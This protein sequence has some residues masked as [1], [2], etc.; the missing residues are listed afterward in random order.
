MVAIGFGMSMAFLSC[1]LLFLYIKQKDNTSIVIKFSRSTVDWIQVMLVL[2][3]ALLFS[4]VI[5]WLGSR[6]IV[7]LLKNINVGILFSIRKFIENGILIPFICILVSKV[8]FKAIKK[9]N[10]DYT[11]NYTENLAKSCMMVLTIILSVALYI[12]CLSMMEYDKETDFFLNRVL[13]W[14]ITAIG[15]KYGFGF[16]C[17]KRIKEGNGFF[18]RL[19][20]ALKKMIEDIKKNY[21]IYISFAICLV[22]IILVDKSE[23]FFVEAILSFS[24]MFVVLGLLLSEYIDR[25]IRP[26]EKNG[27]KRFDKVI[28]KY[29]NSKLIVGRLGRMKYGIKN[30]QIIIEKLDIKF[31]GHEEDEDYKEAVKFSPIN[32]DADGIVTPESLKMAWEQLVKCNEKQTAYL[33]MAHKLVIDERRSSIEAQIGESITNEKID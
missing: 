13:M 24:G 14:L 20:I 16:R 29:E 12:K 10:L 17:E 25:F 33:K 21:P 9:N 18:E 31:D 5:E 22:I 1:L 2:L 15:T 32:I 8:F 19:V 28:E 11:D 30:N 3:I 4:F 23:D 6:G 7:S 26:T 27:K